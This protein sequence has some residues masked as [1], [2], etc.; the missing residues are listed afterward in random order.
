M[1]TVL[2]AS[3]IA[4]VVL[5]W[6]Y[7]G[8]SFFYDE[9]D[10]IQNR[11]AWN[12]GAFLEPHNEH[13]V[14]LPAF[15]FKVLFSV[16]GIG[17]YWPYVVVL[18]I[19]H[20]G[21]A[22]VLYAL[23]RTWTSNEIS[24]AG[25]VVFLFIGTG[26]EVLLWPFEVSVTVSLA[27]GLGALLAARSESRTGDIA[28]C[29]LLV[30]SLASASLGIPFVVGVAILIATRPSAI[31]RLY[32]VAVPAVLYGAWYLLYAESSAKAAN[33]QQ[34]PVFVADS[35]AAAWAGVFGMNPEIG[36][37]IMVASIVAVVLVVVKRLADRAAIAALVTI[38]VVM[39]ALL[40]LSR[41]GIATPSTPRYVYPGVALMLALGALMLGRK[42]ASSIGARVVI[43][44]LLVSS[45]MTNV[46]VLKDGGKMWRDYS[47]QVTAGLGAMTLVQEEVPRDF[48][49]NAQYAPQVTAGPYFAAVAALGSPAMTPEEIAGATPPA[50]ASAD[51]VLR[52][53][54]VVA[55]ANATASTAAGSR[56]RPSVVTNGV[57]AGS[58]GP[59]CTTLN[60]T[61]PGEISAQVPVSAA[62]LEIRSTGAPV[63]VRVSAFGDPAPGE[64]LAVASPGGGVVTVTPRIVA[65]V[66]MWTVLA[67]STA[68]IVMC[69]MKR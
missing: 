51:D 18:V 13:L 24:V 44:V 25:T 52:R 48:Q 66:P 53:A 58:G 19:T 22:L 34:I 33:V 9:W 12:P 31:R 49:P 47:A 42:D 37:A 50:R 10:F 67:S 5:L 3:L 28:A 68:S 30:T 11:R 20:V 27:T 14:L 64:P 59:G 36:R 55:L 46:G 15:I 69:T 35:A 43:A 29:V 60:P 6:T 8:L 39:W 54:G 41:F 2:V 40:C 32:I 45:L 65:G 16:F 21:C 57:A 26:W 61:A 23:L 17:S 4:G 62:G 1:V 7:R 56:P 38:P 63:G